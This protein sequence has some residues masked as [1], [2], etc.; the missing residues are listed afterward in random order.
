MKLYYLILWLAG[1][2][3]KE[4]TFSSMAACEAYRDRLEYAAPASR[5][6]VRL[7]A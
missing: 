3:P 4:V 6:L 1:A 2:E 5:C 7:S